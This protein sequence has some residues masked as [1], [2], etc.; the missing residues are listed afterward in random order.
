MDDLPR[1]DRIQSNHQLIQEL[2][3]LSIRHLLHT[4]TQIQR[5]LQESLIIGTKIQTQR[6][7]ILG[8]NTST[9]CIQGQFS[10]RNSH[11]IDTKIAQSKDA[12]AIGDN[13]NLDLRLGPVAQDIDNISAVLP[14][15]IKAY[16]VCQR[17][18]LRC[19]RTS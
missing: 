18:S 10:Y 13:G 6:Q 17:M 12:R 5:I 1:P 11:A 2:L 9:A 16:D 14:G 15:D 8:S 3:L 19:P 4:S 7:S